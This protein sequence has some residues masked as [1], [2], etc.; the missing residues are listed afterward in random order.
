MRTHFIPVVFEF[1]GEEFS[2]L[3]PGHKDVVALP[4]IEIKH[5]FIGYPFQ[6]ALG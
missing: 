3:D 2:F 4:E 1:C 5:T 6:P